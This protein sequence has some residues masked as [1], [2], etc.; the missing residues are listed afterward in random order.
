M[1]KIIIVA[2]LLSC[3]ISSAMAQSSP[4]KESGPYVEAGLM[5]AYYSEPLLSFNHTMG[6]LKGGYNFN[7]NFALEG[8][9]GANLNSANGYVGSTNVTAQVQNAYGIYGKGS[10]DVSNIVSLYAKIGGTNGTV[11]ASTAYGSG[12][13]SGTSISYGVGVT[14]KINPDVYLSLDYMS[15]YSRNGVSIV[16]PSLNAGYKF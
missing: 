3:A 1:K 6:V 4:N 5:Q 13:S 12:W 15:Y 10:I 14:T 16:G 11:S 9:V 8:M 2:S 7:K